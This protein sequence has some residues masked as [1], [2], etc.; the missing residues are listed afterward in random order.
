MTKATTISVRAHGRVF[1]RWI[2]PVAGIVSMGCGTRTTTHS[3]NKD[4]QKRQKPLAVAPS[5]WS[6]YSAQ[7]ALNSSRSMPRESSKSFTS[8]KDVDR[9]GVHI[10]ITTCTSAMCQTISSQALGV[11][12]LSVTRVFPDTSDSRLDPL[13]LH[14]AHSLQ[15]VLQRGCHMPGRVYQHIQHQ[16]HHRD[17]GQVVLCCNLQAQDPRPSSTQ[18]NAA[19]VSASSPVTLS[20]RIMNMCDHIHIHIH[21]HMYILIY[22][23]IY[24]YIDARHRCLMVEKL[25]GRFK[26]SRP[27]KP[28]S[29]RAQT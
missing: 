16:Q 25:W 2:N 11:E 28:G 24:V 12:K 13:D 10:G 21:L 1:S 20:R 23:S 6:L 9:T 17:A 27:Q 8:S 15:G 7:S 22:I 3:E 14:A 19:S 5:P 29:C 18:Q 26:P 4:D